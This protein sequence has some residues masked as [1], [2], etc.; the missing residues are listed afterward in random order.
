MQERSLVFSKFSAF[1]SKS[2]EP[3][4]HCLIYSADSSGV[5]EITSVVLER[6]ETPPHV[7]TLRFSKKCCYRAVVST[8]TLLC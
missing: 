1:D 4:H 8:G 3:D 2:Q 5:N 6:Y 7:L